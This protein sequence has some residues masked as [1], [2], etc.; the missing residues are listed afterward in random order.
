MDWTVTLGPGVAKFII[1]LAILTVSA[2]GLMVL[3]SKITDYL[4]RFN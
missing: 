3:K 4:N 1:L 2:L